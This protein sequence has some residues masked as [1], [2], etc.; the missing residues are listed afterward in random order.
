[1]PEEIKAERYDRLMRHQQA[2][3]AHVLATRVGKTIEV[4]VDRIDDEGAVA[5]SHWDAPDIDGNVYLS[6]G[7]DLKPGDRLKVL[8]E[9]ADEYDLYARP[10]GASPAQRPHRAARGARAGLSIERLPVMPAKAEN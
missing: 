2:I 5:R 3:S 6:G 9:D 10:A 8:V 1:V 7:R 4:M